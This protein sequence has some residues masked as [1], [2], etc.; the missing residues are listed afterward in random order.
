MTRYAIADEPR[1]GVLA[2]AISDPMW[3]L[4][5]QMLAGSWLALPWFVFNG[6]ALGSSSRRKEWAWVSA[7][8]VGSLVVAGWLLARGD[9]NTSQM[10]IRFGLLGIVA[11]KITCSYALYTLQH[12]SFEIWQYYGGAASRV[13][14][15]VLIG[16]FLVRAAVLKAL[17]ASTLAMLVLS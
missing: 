13:G 3:P 9:G 12:R 1:P 14:L 7:S 4:L 15:Y 11:V 6:M 16:G 10:L 8:L 5:A 17:G 2:S